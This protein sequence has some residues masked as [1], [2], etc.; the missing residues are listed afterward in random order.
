VEGGGPGELLVR[1]PSA[2]A[3]RRRLMKRVLN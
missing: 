3:V 1:D 2:L